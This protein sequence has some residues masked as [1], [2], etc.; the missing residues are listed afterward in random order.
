MG[1][2]LLI[3][4]EKKMDEAKSVFAS[5]TMWANLVALAV[6]IGTAFGLDLGLDPE[7]QAAIVGGAVALVNMVLR[8]IT[9]TPVK[10]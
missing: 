3:Q 9:K 6:S 7:G 8:L 5:K 10:L 2:D 4:G 1:L